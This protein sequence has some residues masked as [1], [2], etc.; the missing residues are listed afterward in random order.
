L[1]ITWLNEVVDELPTSDITQA[2][3]RY[4]YTANYHYFKGGLAIGNNQGVQIND[5]KVEIFGDTPFIDFH[6]GS[7]TSDFTSR[8]IEEA[9]GVLAIKGSL[10][11]SKAINGM[12]VYTAT[13][14]EESTI[15]ITC[16][17]THTGGLV[18]GDYNNAPSV[19]A[20]AYNGGSVIAGSGTISGSS[21]VITL[22]VANWSYYKILSTKP[23]TI[24]VS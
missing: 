15:T 21:G 4:M 13:T 24:A 19:F 10:N 2:H 5:G 22:T 17:E 20:F 8:I 3:N 6:F 1:D 11:V 23:I 12:Y 14:R 18:F 16:S 7:S 9:S